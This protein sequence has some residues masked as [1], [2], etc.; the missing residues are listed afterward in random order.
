LK[1]THPISKEK[2]TVSIDLAK[3]IK[4]FIKKKGG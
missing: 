1:F 3:D 4:E 2:V